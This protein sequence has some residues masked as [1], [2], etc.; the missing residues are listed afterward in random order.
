MPPKGPHC[1]LFVG[2]SREVGP[3]EKLGT[4]ETDGSAN[5]LVTVTLSAVLGPPGASG[6]NLSCRAWP[7]GPSTNVQDMK[8]IPL[9]PER[10]PKEAASAR[11]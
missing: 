2:W 6:E 10:W 8:Q 7:T 5:L 4:M 11:L 9:T 3:E 1:L